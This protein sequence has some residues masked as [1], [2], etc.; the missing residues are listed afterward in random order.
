MPKQCESSAKDKF[1]IEHFCRLADGHV[2]HRS[3]TANATWNGMEIHLDW[4]D[5]SEAIIMYE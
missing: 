2:S 4:L 1:G 3:H 5:D